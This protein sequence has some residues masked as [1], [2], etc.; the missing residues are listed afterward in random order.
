MAGKENVGESAK[1]V[2]YQISVLTKDVINVLLWG[3][4]IIILVFV[5]SLRLITHVLKG[6]LDFLPAFTSKV[7]PKK[8]RANLSKMLIYAGISMKCEEVISIALLYSVLISI[9]SGLVTF[10]LKMSP[11]T[12]FLAIVGSFIS[13]WL[14]LIMIINM[15]IYR[16]TESIEN[17]LPD[18]LDMVAQ[19]MV[20][21]MT[22]YN[23]L[24]FAARPE[25]GPLALEIQA[26]ARATLTGTP[27]EEAL[28][29]ITERIKSEKLERSIKL[30]VQ[31]IRSGGELPSVLQG[32]SRDMRAERNLKKQ[33][34]AET[35]AYSLFIIFTILIGAPLLFGI[36]LQFITIFNALFEQTGIEG[37]TDKIASTGGLMT[38]SPLAVSPDFFMKYAVSTIFVLA[39][40]GALLIGLI[41][42]GRPIAGIQNIP[43]MLIVALTVFFL[44]NF[45]LSTVFKGFVTF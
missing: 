22:S 42:T 19:N 11:P 44:V 7:L 12:I 27:L 20:T 6:F 8:D 23:S 24:L 16:R 9:I 30:I 15:L 34:S 43:L 45:A 32:V 29:E 5:L 38:I 21:G 37:L 28:M 41:R 3:A 26:A 1:R 25:F 2:S 31:G 14:I 33:M 35:S 13:I 36:S 17:A 39:F 40:F 4:N 10:S 18:I